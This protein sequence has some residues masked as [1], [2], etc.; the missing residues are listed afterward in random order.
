MRIAKTLGAVRKASLTLLACCGLLFF[1]VAPA[2]AEQSQFSEQSQGP[3]SSQVPELVAD[4][5]GTG[6]LPRLIDLYGPGAD[7]TSGIDFALSATVVGD[8]VRVMEWTDEFRSGARTDRAVQPTNRWIAAVSHS[9]AA[10]GTQTDLRALGVATV[11][12]NPYSNEPELANFVPSDDLGPILMAAPDGAMLVHDEE[13]GS[14]FALVGNGLTPLAQGEA[15]AVGPA[16]SLSDAQG[17]LWHQLETLPQ[18]PAN[19]GFLIAGLTL[20][21]VVILLAVFVLVP[22]RRRSALDP[23]AALGVS[24]GS[25]DRN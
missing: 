24:L 7:G 6:L 15:G 3:E 9:L 23:E 18:G 8:V 16:M 2:S 13:Q 22:D 12:I 20:A 17:S 25:R 19:N 4:Y 5:F 11:W 1:G 21:F 10:D 14:W